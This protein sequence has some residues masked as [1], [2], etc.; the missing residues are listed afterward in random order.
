[1]WSP[2]QS[3]QRSNP[4]DRSGRNRD[5]AQE[6]SDAL[7]K[8]YDE[9]KGAMSR[10]QEDKMEMTENETGYARDDKCIEFFGSP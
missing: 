6:R 10:D 9:I 8:V 2:S 7:Q 5:P 3:A 4:L 1:M